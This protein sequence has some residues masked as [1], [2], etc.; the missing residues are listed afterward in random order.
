[1][2][3]GQ[4]REDLFYRLAVIELTFPHF[5][6]AVTTYRSS[7]RLCARAGASACLEPIVLSPAL[8]AAL[9]EQEWPGNVRQLENAITR[10]LTLCDGPPSH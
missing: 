8:R 6:T 3:K 10:I 9:A 1:V 5:G 2:A 4:F 7:S